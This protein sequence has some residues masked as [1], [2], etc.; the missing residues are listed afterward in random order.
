MHLIMVHDH[1]KLKDDKIQKV[2]SHKSL[3][4]LLARQYLTE[5]NISK[6][7]LGKLKIQDMYNFSNILMI[8][9]IKCLI[10]QYVDC[11]LFSISIQTFFI[12]VFRI[13]YLLNFE[14][15]LL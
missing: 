4:F 6:T 10:G 3:E 2:H 8:Q 12:I 9:L 13:A 1:I 15:L 11:F 5:L 14:L 7:N